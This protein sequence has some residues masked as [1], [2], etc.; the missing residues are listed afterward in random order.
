MRF[1][2]PAGRLD[3]WEG[4][5]DVSGHHGQLGAPHLLP[6]GGQQRRLLSDGGVV[7]GRRLLLLLAVLSG[8]GRPAGRL[9]ALPAGGG[10]VQARVVGVDREAFTELL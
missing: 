8:R 6:S 7:T 3:P 4:A 10:E 5:D 1:K 9:S 2:A